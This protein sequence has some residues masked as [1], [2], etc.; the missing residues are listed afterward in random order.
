MAE[1]E[2]APVKVELNI[3]KITLEVSL[4][5]EKSA[6]FS[7]S[8][9]N[10]TLFSKPSYIA[11]TFTRLLYRK[12]KVYKALNKSTIPLNRK[13]SFQLIIQSSA[14]SKEVKVFD[15]TEAL[16]INV[17][18]LYKEY[19]AKFARL[20]YIALV[21]ATEPVEL[22]EASDIVEVSTLPSVSAN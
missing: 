2:V 4:G 8:D 16:Q 12:L 13:V 7:L 21:D 1:E 11:G 20:L 6:S 14:T 17:G 19:E 9:L 15:L 22:C 18:R 10:P 5:T 3:H